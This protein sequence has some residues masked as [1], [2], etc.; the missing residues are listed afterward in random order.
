MVRG[1]EVWR[2]VRVVNNGLTPVIDMQTTLAE[3][4]DVSATIIDS[5][6]L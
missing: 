3:L 6:D 1:K 2:Q 5:K 4:G